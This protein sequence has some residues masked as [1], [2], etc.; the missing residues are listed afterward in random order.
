MCV[1]S[2]KRLDFSDDPDHGACREFKKMT[3]AG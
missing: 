2:N 3:N 1:N